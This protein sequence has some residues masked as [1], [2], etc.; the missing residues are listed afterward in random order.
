MSTP[1]PIDLNDDDKVIDIGPSK[2]RR[3][4]RRRLVILIV[5]AIVI[6]VALFRSVSIYI[7]AL[8]FGSLG[9]SS[10]YWYIFRTKLFVFLIFTALTIAILRGAFW[11]LERAFSA[12]T[13]ERRTL[14][15]NNQTISIN[16]ARLFRPAAWILSVLIGIGFGLGMKEGWREIALYLNQPAAP[17]PDDPIFHKPLSFYLFSLPVHQI[18]SG[19]LIQ[20]TLVI[21][22]VAAALAI[23]SKTQ[24][25]ASRAAADS[26]RR[27]TF[28]AVSIALAAFMLMLA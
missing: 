21:L 15:V 3:R 12:S 5:A 28:I 1:F 23:L 18:L 22:I 8:W 20:I 13:L 9:Y 27:T 24:K 16:P 6:L 2:P 25:R 7:S 10:V 4:G 19:W 26:V 14:V 11:L 17:T